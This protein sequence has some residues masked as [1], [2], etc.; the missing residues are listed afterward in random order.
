[1]KK[2]AKPLVVLFALLFLLSPILGCRNYEVLEI[3]EVKYEMQ[4]GYLFICWYTTEPALSTIYTCT[5]GENGTCQVIA[6]EPEMGTL[7]Q[8]RVCTDDTVA[9]Y[10]IRV[11]NT[12]GEEVFEEF[13]N[14]YLTN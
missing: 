9:K 7:H 14:P 10:Q 3:T 5:I 6:T 2:F 4:C 13:I 12:A 1:M 11:V 8:I